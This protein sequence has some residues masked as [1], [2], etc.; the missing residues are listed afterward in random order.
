MFLSFLPFLDFDLPVNTAKAESSS[1]I[2]FAMNV[3]IK[4]A[5]NSQS[6]RT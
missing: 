5:E 2:G 1:G 4:S 6:L 3:E